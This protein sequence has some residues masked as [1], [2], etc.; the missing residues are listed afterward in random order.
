MLEEL[1]GTMLGW[2]GT[3]GTFT[4]YL[5]I[6]RGWMTA[7]TLGYALLNTIGGFLGAA[8]AFTYGAWPALVSNAVWGLLGACGLIGRL[9]KH[10]ATTAPILAA[11]NELATTALLTLPIA[12][13]AVRPVTVRASAPRAA[14]QP[15]APNTL[16]AG[17]QGH[18]SRW[19]RECTPAAS[20]ALPWLDATSS[21]PAAD[22]AQAA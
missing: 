13:Q 15:T 17:P 2:L 12:T 4:A 20:I 16:I 7:E 1:I 10:H 6:S 5:M 18:P 21:T 9:R 14:R 22:Q 8:G 3:A 11:P 19:H